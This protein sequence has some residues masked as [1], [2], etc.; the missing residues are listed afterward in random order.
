R[1]GVEARRVPERGV[2]Y[3]AIPTG[4]LRRAWAW[5]NVFDLAVNVPAGVASAARLLVR[6]RPRV[7]FATGGFVALPVV[8]A[9][10]TLRVPIVIHEQTT[11]PG[12][13]NRIGARFARRIAVTFPDGAGHFPAAKVVVTGN[14]LRPELRGGSPHDAVERFGLDAALPLVYVTGGAQGAQRI[15]RAV[16]DA[17]ASL[18]ERAQVIHQCG[19]NP[20]IGALLAN[21]RRLKD[22]GARAMTLAVPDADARLVSLLTEVWR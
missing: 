15:N 8:L 22:M 16:G 10:A 6:L 17:L 5:Q 13:A 1:A 7:V 21:P 4:K 19:D 20:S 3:L 14:P 12:L 9:A 11:V 18:L 2:A